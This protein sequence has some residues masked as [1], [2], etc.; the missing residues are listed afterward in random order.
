MSSLVILKISSDSRLTS[1]DTVSNRG[2]SLDVPSKILS[3]VATK[4][5]GKRCDVPLMSVWLFQSW[6]WNLG[7]DCG[8]SLD[9][10]IS[11][12]ISSFV[13]TT[14]DRKCP[15]VP[16]YPYKCWNQPV[17]SRWLWD[18]SPGSRL[19]QLSPLSPLT[20][21]MKKKVFGVI[22]EGNLAPFIRNNVIFKPL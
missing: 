20:A 16:F 8:P 3:F 4:M 9:I 6:R 17:V 14:K 2:L 18:L 7:L 10:S 22:N 15:N 5:A 1:I 12:T 19:A 13:A 21:D 11:S